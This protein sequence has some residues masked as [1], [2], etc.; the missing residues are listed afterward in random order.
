M[1]GRCFALHGPLLLGIEDVRVGARFGIGH[2]ELLAEQPFVEEPEPPH[3]G[4]DR[5]C[6]HERYDF[7]RVDVFE[8]TL[9]DAEVKALILEGEDQM[10]FKTGV[11][12]VP[13]RI[14]TPSSLFVDLVACPDGAQVAR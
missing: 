8:E 9:E 11:R 6:P 12:L 10:P 5:L 4:A 7:G 1:T 13:R 14:D 2:I 3:V